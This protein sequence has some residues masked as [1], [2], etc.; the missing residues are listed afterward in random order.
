MSGTALLVT[1][2][3]SV[4]NKVSTVFEFIDFGVVVAHTL[5]A[6][7]AALENDENPVIALL[8][9]DDDRQAAEYVAL[10]NKAKPSLPVFVLD[11]AASEQGNPPKGVSGYLQYPVQYR[12]L[13][14]ILRDAEKRG[15][16]SHRSSTEPSVSLTGNSPQ[17]K[18]IQALVRHVALTDA[19]EI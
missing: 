18:E 11:S 4:Q 12:T 3:A 14:S 17:L 8:A 10:I 2:D 7:T 6:T 1:N 13:L 19:N 5:A 9:L 16:R 15:R